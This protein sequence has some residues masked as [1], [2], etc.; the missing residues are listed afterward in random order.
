ML[1]SISASVRPFFTRNLPTRCKSADSISPAGDVLYLCRS[2]GQGNL[3]F[4]VFERLVLGLRVREKLHSA[5]HLLFQRR[6]VILASPGRGDGVVG[7][8][9]QLE[10]QL[11]ADLH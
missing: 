9:I 10:L 1:T 11:L 3:L 8:A 7:S 2:Q 6:R 5:L 4:A